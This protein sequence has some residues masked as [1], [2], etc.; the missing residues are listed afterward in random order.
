MNIAFISDHASPLATPGGVDDGGQNVYVA[1]LSQALAK[2]GYS[3]DIYTRRNNAEQPLIVNWR[4]RVRVI[5]VA[6]GPAHFIEK[7]RL[8]PYMN[9]FAVNM[10]LFIR[11]RAVD[12]D[13][14]HA[15][16]FMSGMVASIIK[17]ELGVPYVITFHALGLVRKIHQQEMDR[18]P[19]ERIDIERRLV[20][21]ADA[22]IAECPQDEDDL[23][24]LY[25]AHAGNIAIIPC[26]FNPKE[27]FP[28]DKAKAREKLGLD[29][30]QKI[31]LQ[32][33]RMV[34]RKGVDNVICAM[35]YAGHAIANLRLVIVGGESDD[36]D[37]LCS[38]EL[39]R[40]RAVAEAQGVTASVLFA[41]RKTRHV[42]KYYYAAADVFI[43]TPWYE[44][45]GITP[46]EA[47]ACGTPVV[48]ARVGGIQYSVVDGSTGFLV[49]PKNPER[50]AAKVVELLDSPQ[51]LSAMSK[52]AIK[53]VHQHFTW[54]KVAIKA[55]A[56]YHKVMSTSSVGNARLLNVYAARVD[57]H[58]SSV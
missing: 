46:L 1:E 28:I 17:R 42:L 13:L 20:R 14:V 45:F 8:L 51:R 49:P 3:V 43:T 9:Q 7:E 38:P 27:F 16:F 19:K 52:A 23:I 15:H 31:L 4:P 57:S 40:L 56:V 5:H 12:Y 58:V 6:A 24:E 2:L 35:K 37:C 33:G 34:P 10:I 32:L 25:G 47:M 50:L 30:N 53:R 54:D 26:G 36:P 29:T 22:I 44:P 21:D 39:L 48:G 18:F 55:H 11:S 41:G